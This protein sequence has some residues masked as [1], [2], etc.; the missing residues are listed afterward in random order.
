MKNIYCKL[1]LVSLLLVSF[2]ASVTARDCA[3][4]RKSTARNA[5]ASTK[6][7]ACKR[8][9]STAELNV[10][11]VRALINGYGNMWYDGSVTQYHLPKNSNTCPLYCAALWIGGTD[12]ND[13]LR[14]AALRFGQDGDDYWPGPLK[15]NG[16]ASVDLPICN[17]YDKH[18]VITKAEVLSFMEHFDYSGNNPVLVSEL[19]NI[20]DVILNWPAKGEG[21]DLTS[22][23]APFYDADHDG[24]YNPYNGDYPWYDFN[25]DLC[26]R[27]LKQRYP[28]RSSV[29]MPTMEE[30]AGI[31]TGGI[32]SDQVLKGDQTIWWVFND[33]GNTH[34]ETKGQPIGIEIRAQ[35]FAFSTNDKINDMTFYSY[36][37]INRS[38]YELK[39]TYFSQW[40]D[41][42]L[43]NAQDD[44][45]GCDVRR[46]LGYCYNGTSTDSPGAGSYSG[47]PP[48]VG[49]DFFQGPYMDPDL[50][51]NPKID[52]SY[53]ENS[54]NAPLKKLLSL[55]KMKKVGTSID[56]L[57]AQGRQVYDTVDISY[58]ADDFFAADPKSWYFKQNDVVGNC[59]ING[60]NFGNGIVDD[61]RFGM[62]R[63]VYYNNTA[64]GINGEPD[65]AS[66]YYYYLRGM[67][68]DGSRM[69]YGGN[70]LT[71]SLECDFMFPDDS[72]PW[73][74]GTNGVVPATNPDDWNEIT[75]GNKPSDR[76]FM[77]SAGP[78]TLKPG[79]L[80]YI[81]VGIP[82]A[83]ATSGNNWTSV[84]LLRQI[85][86]VCQRLFENCFKV[87]DGPDAPTLTCQELNNEIILYLNY[88]NPN[89]NN[90]GESYSEDSPAIPS[91]YTDT[92]GN[93][94][95]YDTKYRFEGY[96]IY[97][98]KDE[99]T[100]IADIDDPTKAIL[101]FQCDLENYYDSVIDGS[102][103]VNANGDSVLEKN[104][105]PTL[106]IGTLINYT[107]DTRT[108]ILSGKV[109]VEG[110][111]KGIQH[112]FRVTKDQ[113]ATGRNTDL[114]NNKE[115]YFIAIAYAHNRYKEYSQTEA[116]FLD[117]QK[118]PYLAGRKREKDG[119]SIVPIV[120]IP[121][122][123]AAE[124]GGKI[125]QS[126]FGMCPQITRLGGYGNGGSM[127]RLDSASILELMGAKGQQ[128]KAPGYMT[129]S[130]NSRGLDV[131]IKMNDAC[132]IPHPTYIENAGPLNVRVI[133]PLKIKE[134]RFTILF[135]NSSARDTAN[136][137]DNTHW[138]IIR[139][140]G[141]HFDSVETNGQMRY[142][143]TIWSDFSIGRYNEQLFLDLG[144]AITLVNPNA[145]ASPITLLSSDSTLIT[146]SPYYG[147]VAQKG[148]LLS[149]EIIFEDEN[150]QWLSGVP[151]NDNYY[152][153]NWIHA[154]MQ[155]SYMSYSNFS[156]VK[157]SA[158]SAADPYMDEDYF[159]GY[160]TYESVGGGMMTT[161]EH[162][163]SKDKEQM[164]EDVVGGLWSPYALV[165]GQAFHPGFN[166]SYLMSDDDTLNYLSRLYLSGDGYATGEYKNKLQH[167]LNVTSFNRSL[168]Y[169][170]MSLLPSVRI[171]FTSD[172]T[173]WTRCPV[174]EM[175]D[176]K[177]QSEGNARKFMLRRHASVNKLGKTKAQMA[178]EGLSYVAGSVDD[179]E[180]ISASGMGWFPGYAINTVTGE[181]LNIM[182]GE[183]S[184]Y[185]NHNGRDMMWNP[186]GEMT[187]G[188]GNYILGGRHF[189]YVMNATNQPFYNFALPSGNATEVLTHYKTPSYDAGRWAMRMLASAER[190]MNRYMTPIASI[191][192][193]NHGVSHDERKVLIPQRDSIAMLY[194]SVAWVNMPLVS[195]RHQF[196][197]PMDIPNDV[198]INIDVRSRYGSF[199]G[200]NLT[201]S[202]SAGIASA[203]REL[204]AY[205]FVL[206]AKDAVLEGLAVRSNAKQA[207][208]DSL[209]GQINIVPNPYY[210]YSQYETSSQLET[211]VRIVNLPTGM[212]NGKQQGC[213]IR[214]YTVD[215]TLVRTI[216][217]TPVNK[218]YVDWD[219]HN[220][221]GI[222]IAGGMYLIH[223]DVPGIGERVIKWFGTMRPVD[224][225]SFGF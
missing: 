110:A 88:E 207:Y 119:G 220:Q 180:Y 217:P 106:P 97:Q 53:I 142:I 124:D 172:T 37:I 210:S 87:L 55:Y 11:N 139:Q 89:S 67:W 70:A 129:G 8:A 128:A 121:H 96:Q 212:E 117:G 35:A 94:K 95:A 69:K 188:T 195:T 82:F 24:V 144:I 102:Y 111:N 56:S 208:I 206:S 26:P 30:E 71:G 32:L 182:F 39:N 156:Q 68:T 187:E 74:W 4:Q 103:V 114:V 21:D 126:E 2:S 16:T 138:C 198:T 108:G 168:M 36:E 135:K 63:F 43:G 61:E 90:Y 118:E 213:L 137:N 181:R 22:Y 42:D 98:L 92:A 158:V 130:L 9:Q 153:Y 173:K 14:I 215:G 162:T 134:G 159:T 177:T 64:S 189:I 123:P 34:T 115:Y 184:R 79:A 164:F 66:D 80:N 77:Q 200:P 18:F 131:N 218:T 57:D 62:R 204:P 209:L 222:P 91:T 104:T 152:L 23:L 133:D 202:A 40:V 78:F 60:V 146:S 6:A 73:H 214:I 84:Q 107:T 157:N 147:G 192:Y 174:I 49:I 93:V 85:D 17:Y 186:T 54:T 163:F 190:L 72:D 199:L 28:E 122:S 112:V 38:S 211:K 166:F 50:K 100:S 151:D 15:I 194:A 7:A 203:N 149:S 99:H 51:D 136:V 75:A 19:S 10:N 183:D 45:V 161:R 13:N 185:V 127:L 205:Q 109:M 33:M 141:G 197:N 76:R 116:T 81:T 176:D 179:P 140:D 58:H 201:Q 48:A 105:S 167:Q 143:D 5:A 154:G 46:G 145:A 59:A 83:Q 65:K 221:T 86:D 3:W 171:V 12:V 125:A 41:P 191:P 170:D 219:L 20:P 224:L 178:S 160:Q 216:G 169:S 113:F 47:I 225:N 132:L 120:A 175:C 223:V 193:V 196:T 25:N 101:I 29:R 31:V 1:V 44:F 155:F 165:S 148:A 27:T 52:I 150:N